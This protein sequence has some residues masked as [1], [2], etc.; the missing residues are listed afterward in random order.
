MRFFNITLLGILIVSTSV[1]C[2][3]Q[4]RSLLPGYHIEWKK[5]ATSSLSLDQKQVQ[6]QKVANKLANNPNL[7]KFDFQGMETKVRK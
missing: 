5:G 7:M 4:K 3:I 6:V 2:S 1:G